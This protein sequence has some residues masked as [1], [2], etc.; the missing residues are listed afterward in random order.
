[1][2]MN[3][4]SFNSVSKRFGNFQALKNISF[5]YDGNGA[6]GY[7]GPNGAGK[8]TSLK[9]LV[10]L[11]RP[12]SGTVMINNINVTKEPV[13]ALKKIGALIE[14]PLPYPYLRVSES[15]SYV[16]E[17]RGINKKDIENRIEYYSK[18][19]ALPDLNAKISGLSKGQRQRVVFAST[20]IVDPEILILDE[21]TS[22]LD[23]FERK[24][25]RD[26][27][28]ELKKE[29]LVFMSSHLLSEV[30]ETCDY[31]VFINNGSIKASGNIDEI[32]SSFNIKKVIA[33]FI[34]NVDDMLIDKIKK[35]GYN[36]SSY[37]KN[38][39]IID[40]DG[41]D[42]SRARI[43]SDLVKIGNVIYYDVVG[44][45]LEEAYISILQGNNK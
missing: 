17:L 23:P 21:P 15:L 25:F 41:S 14:T 6:I 5:S 33:R 9:I 37:D 13:R 22:G 16:A 20:L 18:K 3:N 35:A 40:F 12:D 31:V 2:N 28:L 27:I 38:S 45:Q 34:E 4:I 30:S 7:L 44:S 1:M 19:L 29:K 32:S 24:L 8:T 42:A 11:I 36:V 26:V 39:V 43:L 10:N